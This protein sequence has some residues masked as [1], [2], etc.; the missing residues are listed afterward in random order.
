MSEAGAG[1]EPALLVF[2]KY[3]FYP[4]NYPAHTR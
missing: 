1:F 4:L 2:A 3:P